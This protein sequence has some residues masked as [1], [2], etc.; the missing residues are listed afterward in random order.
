MRR[1]A[2]ATVAL[3]LGLA[4]CTSSA[5]TPVSTPHTS[6]P[7]T[8]RP[9][10]PPPLAPPAIAGVHWTPRVF[11]HGVAAIYVAYLGSG[12]AAMWLN[13]RLL[14]FRF[15]PGVQYPENS[16]LRAIDHH[17]S[18]W[19]PRF[20]AAFNGGYKLSDGVGGY[21]YN[22]QTV[23]PLRDGLAS[24]VISDSGTLAVG[25]WGRDFGSRAG[26][27]TVRQNLPPLVVDGRSQATPGDGIRKWGIPANNRTYVNRSALGQLLDGTLI[28]VFAHDVRAYDMGLT[29][30]RL[31]VRTAINLDMN[32]GWPAAFTYTHAAGKTVGTRIV[33]TVFHDPS[34][35]F[36]R[37]LK[38]FVV[39]LPR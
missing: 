3:A 2:L 8:A 6:T 22:G 16:P 9:S 31:T 1:C 17:P 25:V 13:P 24:M 19:V 34:I 12:T 20:V 28:Y 11:V 29:L 27:E 26:L 37:P 32:G 23:L 18:T 10:S 14:D 38:D 35:Y 5:V 39:V 15:I 4:G 30:V 21:Y 7:V 36:D 33:A